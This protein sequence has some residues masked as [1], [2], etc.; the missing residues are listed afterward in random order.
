M[1]I[2]AIA[3]AILLVIISGAGGYWYFEIYQPKQF[4]REIV[5]IY[6]DFQRGIRSVAPNHP[7]QDRSEIAAAVQRYEEVVQKTRDKLNTLKP[8]RKM[9]PIH[10]DF[11]EFLDA[12]QLFI[13]N[14]KSGDFDQ[15]LSDKEQEQARRGNDLDS[16]MQELIKTY[17]ELKPMTQ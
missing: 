13:S 15:A 10:K 9:K 6:V 16:K 11:V 8:P 2:F 1:R 17:P 3:I 12:F 5:S 14:F 4:A 7:T